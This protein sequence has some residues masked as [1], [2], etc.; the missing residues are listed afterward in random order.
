[1]EGFCT[2][3]L[4]ESVVRTRDP[5]MALKVLPKISAIRNQSI[6]NE[7]KHKDYKIKLKLAEANLRQVQAV[8]FREVDYDF[9]VLGKRDFERYTE[10]VDVATTGGPM[11]PPE[12]KEFGELVYQII[13]KAAVR[14][15]IEPINEEFKKL[16]YNGQNGNGN[17]GQN[18]NGNGNGNNGHG[19][20]NGNGNGNGY[21]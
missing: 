20:G 15:G 4:A 5:E 6:E 12:F 1:M 13:H 9:S 19:N 7:F 10:L 18:G 3:L 8:E 21:H 17:Y 14:D 11:T 16:G 2:S